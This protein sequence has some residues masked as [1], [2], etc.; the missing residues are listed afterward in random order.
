MEG[1]TQAG[2]IGLVQVRDSEGDIFLFRT[3]VNKN[4]VAEGRLKEMFECAEIVKVCVNISVR[5]QRAI[6]VRCQSIT[7]RI[8]CPQYL[9]GDSRA[10]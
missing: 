5:F 8:I 7:H 10:R 9:R 3:G 4:L 1:I 6:H 2:R